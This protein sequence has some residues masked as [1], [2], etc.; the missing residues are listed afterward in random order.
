MGLGGARNVA[1][2]PKSKQTWE[3]TLR[4]S[5]WLVQALNVRFVKLSVQIESL[6]GITWTDGIKSNNDYAFTVLPYPLLSFY[7]FCFAN[8]YNLNFDSYRRPGEPETSKVPW[9]TLWLL[10]LWILLQ[11]QSLCKN[12]HW[13]KTY[14]NWGLLMPRMRQTCSNKKCFESSHAAKSSILYLLN[15]L[16]LFTRC[17][18]DRTWWKDREGSRWKWRD[19]VSVHSLWSQEYHQGSDQEP[20]W[21]STQHVLLPLCHLWSPVQLSQCFKSSQP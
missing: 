6:S 18:S 1:I 20:Y 10:R 9:W 13:I 21:G 3:C 19:I 14:R 2:A 11:D 5:T 17:V 4:A 12:S 16:C 8:K 15:L 7:T